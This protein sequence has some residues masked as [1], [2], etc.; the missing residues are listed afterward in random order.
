MRVINERH[1]GENASRPDDLTGEMK[2]RQFIDLLA[3]ILHDA[4]RLRTSFAMLVVSIDDLA[5]INEAYGFAVGDEVIAWRRSSRS[6]GGKQVRADP[7]QLHP[8]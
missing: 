3:G 5:R 7:A 2:R 8:A 4:D 6:V 1:V